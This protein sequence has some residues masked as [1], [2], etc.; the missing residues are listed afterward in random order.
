MSNF[1]RFLS[2]LFFSIICSHELS[3]EKKFQVSN[4][5]SNKTEIIFN[6]PELEIEK[7]KGISEFK[8]NDKV[9]A[10]INKTGDYNDDIIK[11]LKDILDSFKNKFK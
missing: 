6:S 3:A 8:T 5:Y 11:G 9:I 2:L 4:I 10:M 1:I 7:N